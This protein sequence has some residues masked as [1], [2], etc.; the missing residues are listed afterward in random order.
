MWASYIVHFST[1]CKTPHKR[2]NLI[3]FR[4]INFPISKNLFRLSKMPKTNTFQTHK[5]KGFFRNTLWSRHVCIWNTITFNLTRN[6][7]L[8]IWNID[9]TKTILLPLFQLATRLNSKKPYETY[10]HNELSHIHLYMIIGNPIWH[11]W[12]IETKKIKFFFF[13]FSSK[14]DYWPP[15]TRNPLVHKSMSEMERNEKYAFRSSKCEIW[16]S[17]NTKKSRTYLNLL[18][19]WF[20]E[21]E[22]LY[23]ILGVSKINQTVT[24]IS[25]K[26]TRIWKFFVY[27]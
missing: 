4:K 25:I 7:N 11:L 17:R 24:Y 9:R 18:A 21:D 3:V 5:Y 20:F 2:N 26:K 19:C 12:N 6:S 14:G 15:N 13:N 1:I 10:I 8:H 23:L 22:S 16:I 27:T